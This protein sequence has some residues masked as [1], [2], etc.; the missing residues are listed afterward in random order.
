MDVS[1]PL[2]GL[3]SF[4][5]LEARKENTEAVWVSMPLV[6]LRS[7]LHVLKEEV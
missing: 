6:G 4:L 5:Q 1:M 7:F 3:R 2:V